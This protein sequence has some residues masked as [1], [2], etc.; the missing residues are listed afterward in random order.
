MHCGEPQRGRATS[1]AGPDV[2]DRAAPA[3]RERMRLAYRVVRLLS[4]ALFLAFFRGR[5]FGAHHVPAHG[6]VLLVSNHQSYL[7]PVLATLA[8][9]RECNF[10][11]R[12]SLFD[13]PRLRPI[14]EHLN[15]FPVRRDTA[16]LGAIKETLRRLKAGRVVLTF[17]EG[18]RTTDGSIG[19]MRGGVVLLA[20]K[21]RV[22][23]VP[24]AIDGAFESWPRTRKW[25]RAW[26]IAV[27]YGPA[28]VPHE[29]P[30]W[31]DE[32]CVAEIRGRVVELYARLRSRPD[33]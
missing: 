17:P 13:V 19:V 33:R 14:I 1:A 16:D 18:T 12:D 27:A 9:P 15:A 30:D 2:I 22:P 23:I 8:L 32:R 24:V 11:A 3:P 28:V 21:A 25:P 6:G 10:M 26:P 20:R 4:Q 7:D 31:D 5:A 29:Q